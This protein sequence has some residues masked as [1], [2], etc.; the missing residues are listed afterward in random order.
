MEMDMEEEQRVEMISKGF[1]QGLRKALNYNIVGDLF[2]QL[3]E[4][5]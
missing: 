1:D 3:Q 4:Q 2:K 5:N